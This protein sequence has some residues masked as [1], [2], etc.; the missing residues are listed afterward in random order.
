MDRVSIVNANTVRGDHG[1]IVLER[2]FGSGK[3]SKSVE[4]EKW[5]AHTFWVLFI[6]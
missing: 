6:Q 5:E 1:Q 4:T 2:K 3:G